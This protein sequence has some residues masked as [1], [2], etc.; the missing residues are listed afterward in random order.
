MLNRV[1][2]HGADVVTSDECALGERAM[3]LSQELL[4]PG[5]LYH[6]VS[7]NTIL[8]L[9]TGEGDNRLPLGRPGVDTSSAGEE[10]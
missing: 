4:K 1:G 3:E 9:G 2:V 10:R 8:R 5:R 7:N 6:A